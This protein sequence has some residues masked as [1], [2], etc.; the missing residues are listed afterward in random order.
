M[1]T[2]SSF[3]VTTG[4]DLQEVDNAVNQ[5]MKEVQQRYDFKGSN[6]TIAFDRAKSVLTL[7]ADDDYKMKALYDILQSKFVKRGVPLK[8]MKQGPLIPAAGGRVRQE[9]TLAQGIDTETAKKIVKDVKAG[10]FKKVQVAIQ[11]DQLRVSSPSKDELQAVMGFLRG[12]DYGIE[13][14]FG[15]YR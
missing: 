6:C 11:G 9:I 10:G 8:N 14:N 3:D 7:D 13:L 2:Q 5:S 1:T 15:N 12:Q 4:A